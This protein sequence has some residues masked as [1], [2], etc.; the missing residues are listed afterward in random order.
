M[1]QRVGATASN[2]QQTR[3]RNRCEN[4]AVDAASSALG[5]RI[6]NEQRRD[7]DPGFIQQSF[8]QKSSYQAAASFDEDGCDA[9]LGERSQRVLQ[10]IPRAQRQKC[11]A[12]PAQQRHASLRRSV[13][14]IAHQQRCWRVAFEDFRFDRR[15]DIGVKHD[16][17]RQALH[18]NAARSELRIILD[19]GA[20]A[21]QH[22]IDAAALAMD[23]CP[24][25]RTRHPLAISVGK[26]D[27]AVDR[28]RPLRTHPREFRCDPLDERPRE[29]VRARVEYELS[30]N[31][32]VDELSR[33]AAGNWVGIRNRVVHACDSRFDQRIGARTGPTSVRAGLKS[34]DRG[35]PARARTSSAQGVDFSVWSAA[36]AMKSLGDRRCVVVGDH[37]AD[38]RIWLD[39][40]VS[41][42]GNAHRTVE[43][44]AHAIGGHARAPAYSCA[45]MGISSPVTDEIDRRLTK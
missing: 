3:A 16:S 22:R 6:A 42:C 34:H 11:R 31:P 4:I 1:E 35:G 37:A 45:G 33:A 24:T 38:H 23:H 36:N 26:R 28:L 40:A 8:A 19:H 39:A 21:S 41:A 25:A 32:C 14:R 7:E 30:W 5:R 15:H 10:R 44:R 17:S 29:F 9:R 18:P 12:T 2:A 43:Q 20:D 27:G 13:E